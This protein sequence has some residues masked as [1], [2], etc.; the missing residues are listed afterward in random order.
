MPAFNFQKQFAGAVERGEKRQ[1]I[2]AIRKDKRL[3]AKPGDT[4][5]LYTG[6]VCRKLMDAP[7]TNVRPIEIREN[8]VL[9]DSGLIL[10]LPDLDVFAIADGFKDWLEMSNWFEKTHGFP[11]KGHLIEWDPKTAP[12]V[13]DTGK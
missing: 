3:P 1:T 13:K 5:A 4:I 8:F 11:F 7:C 9:C 6:K 10:E 12:S 2:R